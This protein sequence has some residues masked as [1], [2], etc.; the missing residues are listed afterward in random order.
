MPGNS[1]FV[2]TNMTGAGGH[3]VGRYIT[4][5]APRDGTSIG[6]VLP[7][8]ITGALYGIHVGANFA[9]ITNAGTISGSIGAIQFFGGGN[10][11]TLAMGFAVPHFRDRRNG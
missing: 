6:L 11:L 7:G 2:V 9:D 4:E 1:A 10:T 5:F 8:T 3:L